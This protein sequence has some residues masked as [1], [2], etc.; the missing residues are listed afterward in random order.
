[1]SKLEKRPK[2][3]SIE[4]WLE[5]S[6]DKQRAQEKP[7]IPRKWGWKLKEGAEFVL[8]SQE[9]DKHE[10][11][12]THA[13]CRKRKGDDAEK[14]ESDLTPTADEEETILAENLYQAGLYSSYLSTQRALSA[15][16]QLEA[17]Q[18]RTREAA[19]TEE[20]I[21]RRQLKL[22]P[23]RPQRR[24][25]GPALVPEEKIGTAVP[26]SSPG[27]EE[28]SQETVIL[29]T[30]NTIFVIKGSPEGRPRKMLR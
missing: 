9:S 15:Q 5:A 17:Y 20:A 11:E 28:S 1:M 4:E 6:I 23:E 29:E 3:E 22:T 21:R 18:A 27:E 30:R 24:P 14:K 19:A 16:R 8:S 12:R 10:P 26:E 25:H 7:A 2:K 13:T